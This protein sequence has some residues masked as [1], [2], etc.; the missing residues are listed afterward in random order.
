MSGVSTLSKKRYAEFEAALRQELKLDEST[1]S[2]V[3]DQLRRVMS[4]DPEA[5]VYNESRKESVKAWR[6]KRAAE[7]GQ[8]MYEIVKGREAYERRKARASAGAGAEAP[9]SL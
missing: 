7:T 8:S 5:K 1:V 9:P 4:F 6:R 2:G 3:L